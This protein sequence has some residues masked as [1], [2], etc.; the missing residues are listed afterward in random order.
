M[1]RGG[2]W[3]TGCLAAGYLAFSTCA[4]AALLPAPGHQTRALT[5]TAGTGEVLE[6]LAVDGDRVYVGKSTTI[7]SIGLTDL[8]VLQEGP[9][10]PNVS[11]G[12]VERLGGQSFAGLT[13]SFSSPFPGQVGLLNPDGVYSNLL[14]NDGIFDAAVNSLGEFYFVA[15]PGATGSKIF[16]LNPADGSMEEIVNAGGF[17]GGIAFDSDD[18][19]YYAF[20]APFPDPSQIWRFTAAQVAA[21]QLDSTDAETVLAVGGSYL[22]FDDHDDLYV[23]TG[24]G[25]ALE[26]Y[27][28]TTKERLR[29]IATDDAAGF[30]LGKAVWHSARN[31]LIQ[32]F[33]DFSAFESQLFELI[34]LPVRNDFE[35][36]GH[37]DIAVFHPASGTW[38]IQESESGAVRTQNW[39]WSAVTPVTGDYDGDAIAD[40]AVY[41]PNTGLWFV[42]FSGGGG[43]VKEL[44]GGEAIAVPADYDGD[45]LTDCAVFVPSTG[46]WLI[47]QSTDETLLSQQWGWDQ[48]TPVPAD[49]DGDGLADIAVYHQAAGDWYIRQSTDLSLRLQNWGWSEATPVPGDYDGDRLADL[50]VYH[51][52][53]GDWYILRS[54]DESLRLQNWGWS[55]ANA[56]PADYDGDGRFDLTV[57]HQPAG[58]WFILQSRDDTLRFQNWGWSEAIPTVRPPTP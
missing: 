24:F 3:A 56:F 35:R 31:K 23:T 30:G 34:A 14:A 1:F 53:Q 22:T 43:T 40:F 50:A 26:Q 51:R 54:S 5:D 19:L 58:N 21:G 49:Y 52:A 9:L 57:Y 45:G 8:S 7:R 15:N 42:L 47:R 39:G 46:T 48:T 44:G 33:T 16:R 41:W 11:I 6:G 18:S 38:F 2:C 10:P 27:D 13:T 32:I 17:S 20:Q 37:S 4:G 29:V 36:D 12:F 25:N 55:A 28:L